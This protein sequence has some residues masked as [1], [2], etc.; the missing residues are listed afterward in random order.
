M[1][2][3]DFYVRTQDGYLSNYNCF[4][5][6]LLH[7]CVPFDEL[8]DIFEPTVIPRLRSESIGNEASTTFLSGYRYSTNSAEMASVSPDHTNAAD[9]QQIEEVNIITQEKDWID[10]TGNET[11]QGSY[12]QL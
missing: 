11:Q 5:V 3:R 1:P 10:W 9:Q 12:H 2:P 6:C 7:Y 8:T 4:F